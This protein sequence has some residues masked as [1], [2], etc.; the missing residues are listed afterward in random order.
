MEDL[1]EK[2]VI[3]PGDI[4]VKTDKYRTVLSPVVSALAV[5]ILKEGLEK[6]TAEE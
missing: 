3:R 6:K 5:K 2:S 4:P 1:K